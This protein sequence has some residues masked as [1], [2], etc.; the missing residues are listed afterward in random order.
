M[1]VPLVGAWIPTNTQLVNR[2]NRILAVHRWKHLIFFH[3]L[4]DLPRWVCIFWIL[5]AEFHWCFGFLTLPSSNKKHV[6]SLQN[7]QKHTQQNK[8]ERHNWHR[9]A[10]VLSTTTFA[11]HWYGWNYQFFPWLQHLLDIDDIDLFKTESQP[12]CKA[13]PLETFPQNLPSKG[14]T[15][16]KFLRIFFLPGTQIDVAWLGGMESCC[17]KQRSHWS[18]KLVSYDVPE[19]P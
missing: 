16:P 19:Y 6:N 18:L 10:G 9:H 2:S 15:N 11:H 17:G 14:S 13:Q 8:Y 1:L 12:P 7:E 5:D 3:K 4:R